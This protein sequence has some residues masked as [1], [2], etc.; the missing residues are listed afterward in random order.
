MIP[1]SREAFRFGVCMETF[2][3]LLKIKTFGFAAMG[4]NIPLESAEVSF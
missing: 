2:T 4:G 3:Y 1:I